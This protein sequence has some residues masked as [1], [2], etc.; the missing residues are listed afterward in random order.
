MSYSRIFKTPAVIL[1]KAGFKG[2]I[3]P[4][5]EGWGYYAKMCFRIELYPVIKL[6]KESRIVK[7]VFFELVQCLDCG[8]M[9]S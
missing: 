5:P 9:L 6:P 3:I 1:A 7:A 2:V 8:I 4:R